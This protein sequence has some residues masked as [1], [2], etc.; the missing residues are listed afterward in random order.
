[1][2]GDRRRYKKSPSAWF[3]VWHSALLM[4]RMNVEAS[5]VVPTGC[6]ALSLGFC[7]ELPVFSPT[8]AIFVSAKHGHECR[9]CVSDGKAH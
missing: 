6:S 5:T 4:G 3:C 8:K 2:L 7:R 9:G 1:M